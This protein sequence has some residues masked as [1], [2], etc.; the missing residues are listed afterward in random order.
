MSNYTY[1]LF[2]KTQIELSKIITDDYIYVGVPHYNSNV[3]DI[4]LWE[5]TLKILNKIK[6]KCLYECS[7]RNYVKPQIKKSTI[8]VMQPGGNFGDIWKDQQDFRHRILND[9]PY[10]PIVQ[11]PNSVWFND[12]K[13]LE[14]DISIFKKHKGNITVCLRERQSYD[15][16]CCYYPFV[17][18]ILLPDLALSFDINNYCRKHFIKRQKGSGTLLLIRNDVEMKNNPQIEKKKL[19]N[20]MICDWPCMEKPIL[21]ETIIKK[22]LYTSRRLGKGFQNRLTSLCYKRILRHLY[23]RIGIMFIDRFQTIYSTR[24]HVAIIATLLGKEVHL[25]DNS[26]GK[27]FSA[28]DTWMSELPNITKEMP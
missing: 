1:S 18:A 22:I 8:I 24:L 5:S 21:M 2:K 14:D 27:C 6:H 20:V 16:V 15:I 12:L 23:I 9:F 3:G 28:Y 13:Y 4:I 17:N 10:N 26:Y 7:I 25:Y 11:L 19:E